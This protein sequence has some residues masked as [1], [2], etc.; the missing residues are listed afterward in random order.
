QL[1][2]LVAVIEPV[3]V[4][5]G[6][7]GD[8]D[9]VGRVLLPRRTHGRRGGRG[10]A[11]DRPVL[12]VRHGVFAPCAIQAASSC[13]SASVMWVAFPSGMT[14]VSTG[15]AVIRAACAWI[16]AAVS[17]AM[18]SGAAESNVGCCEW[19]AAQRWATIGCT[20]VNVTFVAPAAGADDAGRIQT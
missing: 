16:C 4:V 8:R 5:A 18:P 9:P 3:A 12:L 17:K 7:P 10:L 6:R 1:Q 11:D 15:A 2:E 19:Q 13:R 14:C 20:C